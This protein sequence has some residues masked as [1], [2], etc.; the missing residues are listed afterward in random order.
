MMALRAL[1]VVLC[2]AFA[3]TL[4]IAVTVDDHSGHGAHATHHGGGGS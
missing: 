2:I 1:I 3:T 4:V